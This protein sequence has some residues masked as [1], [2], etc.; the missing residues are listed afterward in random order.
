MIKLD[1]GRI[2]HRHVDHISDRVI[3]VPLSDNEP[4]TDDWADDLTPTVSNAPLLRRSSRIHRAP[5]HFTA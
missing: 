5:A 2:V 1:N 3:S 4:H